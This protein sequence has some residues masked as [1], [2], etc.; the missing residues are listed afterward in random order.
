MLEK[1]RKIY[2][3]ENSD[4]VMSKDKLNI[5]VVNRDRKKS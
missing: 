1:D 4:R 3:A 2:P 5:Q